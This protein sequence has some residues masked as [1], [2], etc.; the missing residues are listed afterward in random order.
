MGNVLWHIYMSLDGAIARPGDDLRW[1][2]IR[3]SIRNGEALT[4]SGG[5]W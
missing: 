4:A 3:T 5:R 1:I 2:G